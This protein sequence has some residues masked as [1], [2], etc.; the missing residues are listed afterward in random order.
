[1]Y[2]S[3]LW[4]CFCLC[5]D[6]IIHE[7]QKVKRG[8]LGTWN[9]ELG[10]WEFEIGYPQCVHFMPNTPILNMYNVFIISVCSDAGHILLETEICI[11]VNAL[12][13]DKVACNWLIEV[14]NILIDKYTNTHICSNYIPEI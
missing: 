14:R 2:C 4:V 12:I 1:M 9:S 5:R 13:S 6:N 11:E 10:T 3:E 8:E 7:K